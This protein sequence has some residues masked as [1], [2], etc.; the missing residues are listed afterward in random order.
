MPLLH[1]P[2]LR[3][4]RHSLLALLL[5]TLPLSAQTVYDNVQLK[6]L[7]SKRTLNSDEARHRI[8]ARV[9][10]SASALDAS[11]L[12]TVRADIDTDS[13][14]DQA[15]QQVSDG[16]RYG[17]FTLRKR[18]TAYVVIDVDVL[19]EQM[20]IAPVNQPVA[21]QPKSIQH[22]SGLIL[23]WEPVRRQGQRLILLH[24]RWAG[25]DIQAPE[26]IL[27]E[28]TLF[29]RHEELI[30]YLIDH[31]S[32][33]YITYSRR[34][35]DRYLADLKAGGQPGFTRPQQQGTEQGYTPIIQI[36]DYR[37][38]EKGAQLTYHL[39]ARLLS[40][41][42]Q[43]RRI[44][45]FTLETQQGSPLHEALL[46]TLEGSRHAVISYERRGME[47]RILT[48]NSMETRPITDDHS[49]GEAYYYQKTERHSDRV[50]HR[51]RILD[52]QRNNHYSSQADIETAG[53]QGNISIRIGQ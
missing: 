48:L 36:L 33:A 22:Q 38:K 23:D 1:I 8:R 46:N 4:L 35:R 37:R 16:T 42:H 24:I 6:I 13:A 49:A 12:I 26:T 40:S 34:G 19:S 14:L 7:S 41:A 5:I 45:R 51:E 43:E 2:L 31:K 10:S 18:G 15:L 44:Q 27:A 29:Q 39:S 9:L 30:E 50:K 53:Q 17:L 20:G 25:P 32:P 47:R 3:M 52:K 21:V 11:S 28:R